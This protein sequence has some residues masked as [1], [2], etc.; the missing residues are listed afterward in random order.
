MKRIFLMGYMGSGKTTLGKAF[1]KA[2][3]LSFVD[4]DWYIEE[5]THRSIRE[6]FAEKGEDGFRELEKNMLHEASQFE[7]VVIACGGGTPCFYNNMDYMN[8]CGITVFLD[9]SIES[10]FRRL[11]VAK[12]NRPLLA[13]KSDEELM[14]TIKD[15]LNKRI[16]Y[17]SE[18]KLRIDGSR[19][20]NRAQ[21]DETVN[22][23]RKQTG[24]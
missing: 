5:R 24:V 9:T 22:E 21:I 20:E 18:A 19:L 6:I 11:K 16:S 13:D 7:N 14:Q 4:L 23:L 10:L 17:Y 1:A 3:G 8:S 2:C 15:G 12:M